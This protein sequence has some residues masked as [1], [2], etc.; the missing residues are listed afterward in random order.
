VNGART[1]ANPGLADGAAM[2]SLLVVAAVSLA[3]AARFPGARGLALLL[4]TLAL[5]ATALALVVRDRWVRL[6]ARAPLLLLGAGLA[7]QLAVLIASAPGVRTARPGGGPVLT[8]LI[9]AAAVIAVELAGL[10]P[11]ARLRLPLLVAAHLVAGGWTLHDARS[12]AIDVYTFHVEALQAVGRGLNPYTITMTDIYGHS[13]FYPPGIQADGRLLVGYIY[14]PLS[15]LLAGA[16]H[17]TAGDY[18]VANLAATGAAGLLL[19]TCRS[20]GLLPAA[21]VLFTPPV[22]R[23]LAYGWTEAYVVALLAATVW[24]ACRRPGWLPPALGLLFAVKQYTLLAAPLVVL[25]HPGPAPWRAAARTLLKA[26][27]IAAALTLPAAILDPRAFLHSVVWF[28]LD[29]PF[30]RDALSYP[31][32]WA[33]ATGTPPGSWW[34]FVLAAAVAAL[35][36]RYAPRTPAGFATAVA[37]TFLAFFAAGRQ[38]FVNYYFFVLGALG[39]ALAALSLEPARPPAPTAPLAGASAGRP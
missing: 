2:A 19:G 26:G 31:A 16:G 13:A 22:F 1:A 4:L 39:C 24:C 34:G 11:L 10:T 14:P 6:P 15:L 35:A 37:A 18:R 36:L 23:V 7:W 32:W 27:L 3:T 17:L 21:L 5:V 9:V 29:A 20:A 28:H 38:A 33:G 25:L 30:R 8:A 12:P